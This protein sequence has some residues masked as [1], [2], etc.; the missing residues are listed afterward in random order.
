M[1]VKAASMASMPA[2][3]LGA[4]TPIWS[5]VPMRYASRSTQIVGLG[6]RSWRS[7]ATSC[8]IRR[9]SLYLRIIFIY[10]SY[11]FIPH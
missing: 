6:E 3:R 11:Y 5:V 8:E 2:Q 9:A 1:A 4:A 7:D 10:K